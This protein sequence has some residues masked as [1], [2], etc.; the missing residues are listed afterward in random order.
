MNKQFCEI[1]STVDSIPLFEEIN[2]NEEI[3]R[4][5]ELIQSNRKASK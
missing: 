2:M 5:R 1:F 3:Q 4:K